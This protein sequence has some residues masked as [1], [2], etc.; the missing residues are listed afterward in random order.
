MQQNV[1][2][3]FGGMCL[4][5]GAV[6]TG[7]AALVCCSW[8][9]TCESL[10]KIYMQYGTRAHTVCP[11]AHAG[12]KTSPIEVSEVQ[13]SMDTNAHSKLGDTQ[14]PM[15]LAKRTVGGL[16]SA[17]RSC[18]DVMLH[19]LSDHLTADC[20]CYHS[21]S[22]HPAVHSTAARLLYKPPCCHA[23]CPRAWQRRA[24]MRQLMLSQSICPRLSCT[25]G[26]R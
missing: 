3:I 25:R 15:R 4:I 5:T 7:G 24:C 13:C 8:M 22:L 16:P 11:Q 17:T 1:V 6:K 18:A 9:Q 12:I 2:R 19:P 26:G 10:Q 20:A 21:A 23:H 14:A